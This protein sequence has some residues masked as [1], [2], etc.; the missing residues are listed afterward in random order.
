ME[1]VKEKPNKL[2]GIGDAGEA[3]RSAFAKAILPIPLMTIS[4]WA[5]KYR[6][7]A[8]K[9][10]PWPG[11]WRNERTP[12]SRAIMDA[13]SPFSGINEGVGVKGTQVGWTEILNNIAMYYMS[14]DPSPILFYFSKDALADEHSKS[15]FTPSMKA[16]KSVNDNVV[17]G[18]EE[19]STI[20]AKYFANGYLYFFGART[21]DNFSSKTA[22]IILKDEISRWLHDV[23]G[24]GDPDKLANNRADAYIK[25]GTQKIFSI[26]TPTIEGMCKITKS[27]NN[28]DQ[29]YYHIPCPHCGRKQIIT[30]DKI[31]FKKTLDNFRD[32]EVYLECEN[33]DCGKL[34]SH[35][36]KHS[37]MLKGEWIATN[38]KGLIAGWHLSSLYSS[39]VPWTKIVDEFLEAYRE[40]DK[41]KLR[42]WT[43]T[44]LAEAFSDFNTSIDSHLI[45]NRL[46]KYTAK[47]PK[48]V[49]VLTFQADIQGDRFEYLVTGWGTGYECWVIEHGRVPGDVMTREFWKSMDDQ[50]KRTYQHELGFK[51]GISIAGIDSGYGTTEVYNFVRPRQ[52][53]RIY[54]VKGASVWDAPLINPPKKP[55][56]GILL[57]IIGPNKGKDWVHNCLTLYSKKDEKGNPEYTDGPNYIHL[58]EDLDIDFIDQLTAEI[59]I[60][61]NG[62]RGW[63]KKNPGITNEGLDLM[64]YGRGLIQILNPAFEVIKKKFKNK[65]DGETPKPQKKIQQPGRKRGGWATN[66]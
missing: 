4:Q 57:Q 5:A 25:K 36:D 61:K 46:E 37:M 58:P 29:R 48:D 47:V 16:T 39:S 20:R 44:R 35:N 42:V 31:K 18:G 45:L 10:S 27:F 9:G 28:S 64:V 1:A 12:A 34:I 38:P 50:L 60:T 17:Y 2:E 33:G 51:M 66:Y 23:G 41:Q 7:V 59:L 54:A 14:I 22:R 40:R 19:G 15:K 21:P 6:I 3:V 11:R 55:K 30:W 24:E 43:N 53:K 62:K 49:V 13:F 26:S 32:G 8:G 63:E 52:R 65:V 56:D